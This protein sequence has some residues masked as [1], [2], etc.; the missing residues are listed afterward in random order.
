[1]NNNFNL[2]SSDEMKKINGGNPTVR[3]AVWFIKITAKLCL[4]LTAA[5]EE[6]IPDTK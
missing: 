6:M 4:C 3:F 2:L 1:M 5:A